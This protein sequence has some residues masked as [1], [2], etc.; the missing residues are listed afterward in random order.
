MLRYKADRRT[1]VFVAL[2]Y[3]VAIAPWFR[4]PYMTAWEMVAWVVM[5]CLLS[6]FC[7][8]IV[9]NTIHAPIFYSR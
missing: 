8:V 4:W 9:H 2:Y 3:A 5:N 1:L 6:F 7:A